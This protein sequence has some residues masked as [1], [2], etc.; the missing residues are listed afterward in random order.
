MMKRIVL[1]RH[2][3]A[4]AKQADAE[5][6]DRSLRKKG[7]KEARALAGWYQT[8]AEVPDLLL[9]SPANRALETALI[10]AKCIRRI[11]LKLCARSMTSINR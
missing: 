3:T 2:A 7:R 8:V 4:A 10:F 9:T 6:F 1:V 11:F 5:D